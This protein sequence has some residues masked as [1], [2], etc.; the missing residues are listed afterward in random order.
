MLGIEVASELAATG[1]NVTLVCGDELNPYL[2]PKIWRKIT[3]KLVALGVT[4]IVGPGATAARVERDAVQLSDGREL[5]STVTIWTAGFS[6][7]DLAAR[8]GLS[9]DADGRL[10]TDET[11]TSVDDPR[12]FAAGD[13]AAPSGLPLRMSCAAAQPLGPAPRPSPAD[14]GSG[15]GAERHG[16]HGGDVDAEHDSHDL[17]LLTAVITPNAG[18][19]CPASSEQLRDHL[20]RRSSVVKPSRRPRSSSDSSS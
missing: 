15:R 4:L 20:A 11:L 2:H 9:T 16:E 7:P 8:S 17:G 3:K 13:S 5:P 6:L 10:L 19:A 12:I 1:R 18:L 14:R